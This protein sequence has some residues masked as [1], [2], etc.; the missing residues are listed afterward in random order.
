M[1][2]IA[3]EN[4]DWIWQANSSTKGEQS[5]TGLLCTFVWLPRPG[6]DIEPKRLQVRDVMRR[7]PVA[8][9][10]RRGTLGIVLSFFEACA[11]VVHTCAACVPPLLFLPEFFNRKRELV[12]AAPWP[13]DPKYVRTTFRQDQSK[14]LARDLI[15]VMLGG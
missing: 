7:A 10:L 8:A 2:A 13:F 14:E 3:A 15:D 6:I 11:S 1:Q 9:L 5:L 12:A 4:Q